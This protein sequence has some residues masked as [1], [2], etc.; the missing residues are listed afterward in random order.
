MCSN[1]AMIVVAIVVVVEEDMA[2]YKSVGT[3]VEKVVQMLEEEDIVRTVVGIAEDTGSAVA[4]DW[5][6]NVV[7][8][9]YD[10]E[11]K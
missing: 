6:A 11:Q 10:L 2:Y 7:E 1:L 5:G 3:V 8:A 9:E 4:V